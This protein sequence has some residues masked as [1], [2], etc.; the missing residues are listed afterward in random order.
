MADKPY[1]VLLIEN[2][3]CG[4]QQIKK[5]LAKAKSPSFRINLA[6]SLNAKSLDMNEMM[7]QVAAGMEFHR[8][9]RASVKIEHLTP[10][11]DNTTHQ[12]PVG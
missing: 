1:S 4:A 7:A 6:G 2:D 3:P 5:L 10:C 12:Q 9:A 8:H 11:M